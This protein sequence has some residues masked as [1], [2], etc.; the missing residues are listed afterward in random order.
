MRS[1]PQDAIRTYPNSAAPVDLH[2]EPEQYNHFSRFACRSKL[3]DRPLGASGFCLGSG[4]RGGQTQGNSMPGQCAAKGGEIW[5]AQ[6]FPPH[7]ELHPRCTPVFEP[8]NVQL[9]DA[10]GGFLGQPVALHW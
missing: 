6:G 4:H 9:I 3:L 8:G 5:R 10:A 1:L 2:V 7:R